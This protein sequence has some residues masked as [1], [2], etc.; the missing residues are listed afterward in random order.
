MR[1]IK[2]GCLKEKETVRT[3]TFECINCGCIFE[4]DTKDL[5]NNRIYTCPC[6]ECKCEVWSDKY[7]DII[8]INCNKVDDVE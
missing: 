3:V 6:P 4:E 2:H 1:I 7:K 8:Y 5:R